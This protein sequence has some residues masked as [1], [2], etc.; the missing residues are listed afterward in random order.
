MYEKT[1]IISI[2]WYIFYTNHDHYHCE[3]PVTQI[4]GPV[5]LCYIPVIY[6]PV[7]G[8]SGVTACR[9]GLFC[10]WPH[11]RCTWYYCGR[12]LRWQRPRYWWCSHRWQWGIL[13]LR[14]WRLLWWWLNIC[15]A[16]PFLWSFLLW[17]IRIDKMTI[18]SAI[19]NN[20]M[21]IYFKI[22]PL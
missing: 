20:I 5:S 16:P 18:W 7:F 22:Y 11:C 19:N 6:F 15:K 10:W 13:L 1:F 4:I 17:R 2:N 9:H 3:L 8:V 14:Y 21:V 12:F